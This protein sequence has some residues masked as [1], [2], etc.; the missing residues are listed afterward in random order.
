M[1]LFNKL[2][3]G[4]CCFALCL[5]VSFG[6]YGDTT[7]LKRIQSTCFCKTLAREYLA[8]PLPC[9]R[10]LDLQNKVDFKGLVNLLKTYGV[11]AKM[12]KMAD[13]QIK[14]NEWAKQLVLKWGDKASTWGDCYV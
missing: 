4:V 11:T 9:Q 13:I 7:V 14:C 10:V 3:L 5:A 12:E 1:V 6:K 2:T 8:Q